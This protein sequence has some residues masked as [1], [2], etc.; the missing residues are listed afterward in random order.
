M[1]ICIQII[2]H[3]SFI[4]MYIYLQLSLYDRNLES[5]LPQLTAVKHILSGTSR[6]APYIVYGPPGTGKTVT[7]VEAI[8][9]VREILK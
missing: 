3:I 4:Y 5:N 9:Q 7:I 8:K 6:P 2:D 1:Y